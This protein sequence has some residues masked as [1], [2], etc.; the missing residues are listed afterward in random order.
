VVKKNNP[1][2]NKPQIS[3]FDKEKL[4]IYIGVLPNLY[5]LQ[6]LAGIGAIKIVSSIVSLDSLFEQIF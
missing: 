3:E 2:T 1:I 5:T 4:N 6:Y